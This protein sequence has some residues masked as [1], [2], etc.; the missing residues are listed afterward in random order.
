[1]STM[2]WFVPLLR[3]IVAGLVGLLVAWLAKHLGVQVSEHDRGLLIDGLTGWGLV[4][5][6]GVGALVAKWLKPRFLRGIHPGHGNG[7]FGSLPSTR[8]GVP[9]KLT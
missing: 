7:P 1:M 2:D 3:Q 8:S 9:R 4:I 6:A 5:W